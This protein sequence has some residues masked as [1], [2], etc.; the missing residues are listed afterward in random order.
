MHFKAL[1]NIMLTLVKIAVKTS[2]REILKT[3]IDR[4]VATD[5]VFKK[6]KKYSIRIKIDTK[7]KK[8]RSV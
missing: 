2:L 7:K 3:I 8:K 1:H 6:E 5:N 4:L